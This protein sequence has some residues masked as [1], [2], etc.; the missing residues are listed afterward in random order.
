MTVSGRNEIGLQIE[1]LAGII[2]SCHRCRLSL[3]RRNAVPGEG[4]LRSH[5]LLIAQAPGERED[6]DG[7][8]FT[9]PSG[10]LFDRLMN[11]AGIERSDVYITNLIKCFLPKCR[12]PNRPEIEACKDYLLREI[13]L[14]R[15]EYLIPLGF[16]ATRFLFRHFGIPC[17]IAREFHT[18]FGS[19]IQRDGFLIYPVRH[20]TA[21][22]FNPEMEEIMI[23]QYRKL[24][25][26]VA[27]GGIMQK[28]P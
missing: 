21:L 6:R 20:P 16:H 13:E 3:T 17:P 22:L 14:I 24:K 12:R 25:E 11:M 9:G 15:P 4:N 5:M 10:I 28:Y 26:F 8:I 7:R 2:R 19:I 23:R 1:G 27:G 18:V